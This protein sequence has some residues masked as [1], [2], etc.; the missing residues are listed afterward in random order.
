[1]SPGFCLIFVSFLQNSPNLHV[2]RLHQLFMSARSRLQYWN[3]FRPYR[4]RWVFEL[5]F[6][7]C[8]RPWDVGY[9]S[10]SSARGWLTVSGRSAFR[11]DLT[12]DTKMVV[13]CVV[14]GPLCD[15]QRIEC[16][17]IAEVV[18]LSD[19]ASGGARLVGAF[20]EVVGTQV[21]VGHVVGEHVPDGNQNRVLQCDEGP[22]APAAGHQSSVPCGQVGVLATG[23]G[24]R[25]LPE[26][27]FEP[28]V[29]GTRRSRR[30]LAGRLVVTRTHP[31]P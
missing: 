30:V 18:E 12:A 31:R 2:R 27:G 8:E 7:S 19:E 14:C 15:C 20:D 16:D 26:H 13:S 25:G 17:L 5:A 24:D 9:G 10:V 6:L 23:G 11:D 3:R 1:M 22:L 29:T 4:Y 21:A 28:G